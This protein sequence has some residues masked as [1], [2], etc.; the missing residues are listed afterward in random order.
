M[1]NRTIFK[2]SP[3]NMWLL[4]FMEISSQGFILSGRHTSWGIKKVKF[5]E[6]SNANFAQKFLFRFYTNIG[7]ILNYGE[8][9]LVT[10]PLPKDPQN[11]V[12]YKHSFPVPNNAPCM[13]SKFLPG[14]KLLP[15]WCRLLENVS[16]EVTGGH[17]K[18]RK[19]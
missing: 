3:L 13:I 15:F 7:Q 12:P 18:V 2:S 14:T 8:T 5:S 11:P 17:Q 9:Y 19:F 1:K 10:A 4:R 6:S 16:L